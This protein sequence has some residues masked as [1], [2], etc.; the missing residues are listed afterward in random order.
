[1]LRCTSKYK[2]G[3]ISFAPG[4]LIDD[5]KLEEWLLRDSP[6]S[7]EPYEP[8]VVTKPVQ[9]E[10]EKPALAPITKPVNKG[11]RPPRPR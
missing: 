8:K 1:M 7:F 6:N 11:G 10:S 2:A 4:D 9:A 5:P 3:S